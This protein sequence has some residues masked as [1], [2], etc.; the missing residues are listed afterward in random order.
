NRYEILGILGTGG[1]A[2][3]YKAKDRVLDRFVAVKVLKGELCSDANLIERF[4]AEAKAAAGL[5]HPNLVRVFDVDSQAGIHYIVMELVEG[6]TLKKYIERKGRI[7][8][9]EAIMIVLHVLA[10]MEAAHRNG[11]IHRDIKPQNI[12]IS[13]NGEVKVTDFGIA[14]VS[15]NQ[16]ISINTLG[17]VHYSSPEQARGA[18]SDF[19][20]DI[21]SL[22]VTL[23]EMV[24]GRVPFDGESTV[25]IALMHL[26]DTPVN[27]SVYNPTIGAS[28][29]KIILKCMQ[30]SP[31]ARYQSTAAL[32]SDLKM[33]LSDSSGSFVTPA[34]IVDAAFGTTRI[35]AAD[36]KQEI[37]R[38]LRAGMGGQAG[39]SGAKKAAAPIK[40]AGTSGKHAAKSDAPVRKSGGGQPVDS[41]EDEG[42]ISPKLDRIM[43]IGMIII[44]VIIITILAFI[45]L[46][47]LGIGKKKTQE[48]TA[49]SKT[50]SVVKEAE[51]TMIKVPDFT[52]KTMAEGLRLVNGKLTLLQ[53][54][55]DHSDTIEA[56]RIISQSVEKG[57]E[58]EPNTEIKL[59]V[60]LGKKPEEKKTSTVPKLEGLSREEAVQAL[61]N[62]VLTV[63]EEE[64]FSDTV[65]AGYVISASLANGVVVE[66][67]TTITIV[68]SKGKE[69]LTIPSVSGLSVSGAK[70]VLEASGFILGG[71][72]E[73][74]SDQKKGLIIDQSPAADT[75]ALKGTKVVVIVSKG[76]RSDA[77]Q[78]PTP[79]DNNTS[80]TDVTVKVDIY[81]PIGYVEGDPLTVQIG[82]D[83]QILKAPGTISVTGK[84]GTTMTISISDDKGHQYEKEVKFE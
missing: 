53:A 70:T 47:A 80:K 27:P 1:M 8:T 32:S 73:K 43:T 9:E 69:E 24:T 41:E 15:S 76:P 2:D 67:N 34:P 12:I 18:H 39:A 13:M 40:A 81:A 60:S 4:R 45:V 38:S 26:Q 48:T 19:R 35:M 21:Y 59:T 55:T 79:P 83:T 61:K 62:A 78:K 64:D 7:P 71:E 82:G 30:K 65:P 6:V 66:Q 51:K 63:N 29:E 20:T 68:V 75:K 42:E 3:V 52:N 36:E 54:A 11:I 22:G 84:K 28:L 58:V 77:D 31:A 50:S 5:S 10:G 37:E 44:G 74:E 25:S 23:Y 49:S 33:A 17:S 57:S 46:S 14:R 72:E 16:T 56:G